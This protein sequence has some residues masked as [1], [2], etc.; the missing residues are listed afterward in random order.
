MQ[1]PPD[2][3]TTAHQLPTL[4]GISYFT[5]PQPGLQG[6]EQ[7]PDPV[8]A[9]ESLPGYELLEEI[10]RGGMGIVYRARD[11]RLN[12][13]VAVKFLKPAI[14]GNADAA[15]RFRFEAQITGQLQHP[16]IP[17]VHEL[18]SL[19]DGRPFLAMKLV[20][21]RTLAELLLERADPQ[22]DRGRFLGIFE[23][24][25]HAVGYAHAHGVLHRDLKPANIM[26]GMHGEVQVMDWGLAK[27][28]NETAKSGEE[29]NRFPES[30]DT[31]TRTEHAPAS[32]DTATCT[33]SVLGTPAYMSPEQAAGEIR[34]LDCRS[35]VF[36][37]GAILCQILTGRPPYRS[38]NPHDALVRA[39]RGELTEAMA[40]L[41]RCGAE[42]DLVTLCRRCLSLWQEDR[43]PDG[44]AV[45][46]EVARIRSESEARARRAELERAAAVVRA[47]EQAKRRRVWLGLAVSLFIGMTASS[48]LA[49]WADRMRQD[50][51]T[52]R[53]REAERADA[54]REARLAEEKAR[55]AEQ[56]ARI[57]EQH[58]REEAQ[59][60]LGQIERGVELFAQMLS[61]I[62]PRLEEQG[63]EP[64]Y[65]QLGRLAERAADQ[66]DAEA[67][68]DAIVVARLQ[69]ILGNTLRELG[70]YAK[71]I[72]VL[73]KAVVTR[74]RLLGEDHPDT[75]TSRNNLALTYHVA[76]QVNK[77][78]PLYEANLQAM[79]AKMGPNHPETLIS[80]NNLAGA[81]M[82][83]GMVDKALPL[84]EATLRDT[85]AALGPNHPQTL[86]SRNNLAV[87]YKSAGLIDKALPLYE[88]TLKARET[89]LGPDH[90]QTLTSR[91]NLAVAYMML[92]QHDKA[93]SIY[94]SMSARME[95]KLGPDHPQ[96]LI[97]R[98]NL[99]SAYKSAGRL[100]QAITLY[101]STLQAAEA[102]LGPDHPFTLAT[103]NNL[104]GAYIDAGQTDKGLSLY[105]STLK[106]REANLGRDH[107]ETIISRNNLAMAYEDAG[108]MD[109]ALPLY[110]QAAAGV[111]KLRFRHEYARRIVHN[112]ISAYEHTQRYDLAEAWRRK[113]LAV[114]RERHGPHSREYADELAGLSRNLLHQK[115]WAEAETVL[116]QCLAIGEQQRPQSWGVH[117]VRSLLGEALLGQKQHAAAEP[118][119]LD[120][121]RGMN[122]RAQDI[123]ADSRNRLLREALG[124]LVQ[125]YETWGK[126]QEAA[127]WRQHL[128][129]FPQ[130]K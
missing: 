39:V 94:E 24:V 114:V 105:E 91:N 107:P 44:A 23:Q 3:K 11:L 108:R 68:G 106:A 13:E 71:A 25:C 2:S 79:T 66:L 118:L 63:G 20:H 125:L 64:L 32:A 16:G 85:E 52:A 80:R 54:E 6:A 99:A 115:K 95:S 128:E 70:R 29:E 88:S 97:S 41:E 100:D 37:L 17:A 5:T 60:R 69:T 124:R 46:A 111:E 18:G 127:K 31:V 27:R 89:L 81:F 120:A 57:A 119:L 74:E 77:A 87:A 9:A 101:E 50:A 93:L 15:A 82:D 33:G 26:V 116:R 75:L 47:A 102:K 92:G 61:G 58:A 8:A 109:K 30:A 38:R 76:G 122:A 62:N 10:G 67:V 49:I 113:W 83:A 4:P 22:Q 103:R 117:Y 90:P 65:A 34:K 110:E 104:A 86:A 84:Y 40:E 78:L 48:L 19:P 35:D 14:A 98:N 59:R 96:T 7:Y 112:T 123:P 72:E 28:L 1:D 126:P 129:M 73:E 43:P 121:Y 12:R 55:L 56:Q 51:E 42:P 45:A 36:A 21:G 130:A 53:R